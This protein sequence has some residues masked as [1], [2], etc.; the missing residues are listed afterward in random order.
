MG[1][2]V[3]YFAELFGLFRALALHANVPVDFVP[4]DVAMTT[5]A[6][7]SA[8]IVTEPNVPAA[9]AVNLIAYSTAGGHVVR[10][11]SA[12]SADEYNTIFPTVGSLDAAMGIKRVRHLLPS[13]S[14]LY[15]NSWLKSLDLA[16]SPILPRVSMV[17]GTRPSAAQREVAAQC[18]RCRGTARELGTERDERHEL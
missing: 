18:E 15:T 9:L 2:T 4:E 16:S 13:V 17:S 14:I 11:G 10:V 8:V 3:D 7:Y 12:A 6:L 5:L 1:H